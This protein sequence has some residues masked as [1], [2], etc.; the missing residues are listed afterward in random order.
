MNKITIIGRL[1]K[2]PTL[3]KTNTGISLCYFDVASKGKQKDEVDFFRCMAWRDKGEIIEKYCSKGDRI[4]IFGTMSSR[5]SES[6]NGGRVVMWNCLVEDF[7]FLGSKSTDKAKSEN[8]NVADV[9]DDD[10]PF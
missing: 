5:L 10:F 6:E 4:A 8:D 9:D 1:T 3:T 2:D 7:E